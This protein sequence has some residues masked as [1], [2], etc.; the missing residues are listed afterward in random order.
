MSI[1]R[2]PKS[3]PVQTT[4]TEQFALAAAR[5]AAER[6]CDDVV[7]LDVRSLSPVSDYCLIATGTSDRQMRAVGMEITDLGEL[8]GNVAFSRSGM[9]DGRW[10]LLDFIDLVVHL[11]DADSREFYALE[12]L[13]GDAPKLAWNT[14]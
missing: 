9:E 1:R 6:H 12:M 13:W 4:T 2:Q 10:V 11:F 8:M 7:I 3:Q 14:E 5:L